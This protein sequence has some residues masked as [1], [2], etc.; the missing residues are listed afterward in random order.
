VTYEDFDR[1]HT[2]AETA[3]LFKKDEAHADDRTKW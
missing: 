2:E 3:T 1:L